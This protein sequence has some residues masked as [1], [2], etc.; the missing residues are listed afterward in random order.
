MS[1]KW[2][3]K[4]ALQSLKKKQFHNSEKK[5]VD[6]YS[7]FLVCHLHTD[8]VNF[9]QKCER[10]HEIYKEK[11]WNKLT[12]YN[13]IFIDFEMKL[14]EFTSATMK[15]F[16]SW[17][18]EKE[19]ERNVRNIEYHLQWKTDNTGRMKMTMSIAVQKKIAWKKNWNTILWLTDQKRNECE[20]RKKRQSESKGKNWQKRLKSILLAILRQI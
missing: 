19:K 10:W 16:F 6:N 9:A 14:H 11:N 8:N 7:V 13:F 18:T 15:E 4:N 17:R 12:I 5:I 3:S 1:R 2:N 20:K